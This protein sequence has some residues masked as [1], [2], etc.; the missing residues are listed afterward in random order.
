MNT[1]VNVMFGVVT[2]WIVGVFI[3]G[4]LICIPANKFWNQSLAGTCLN[5]YQFYY[6]SQIPNILTDVI[7][8]IMPM[9][10]VWS[11]HISKYQKMLLCGVFAV[12]GLYV[13]LITLFPLG[14]ILTGSQNLD[15]FN[16]PHAGHD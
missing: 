4:G 7:L 12:G 9:Q 10:V 14:S 15:L 16:C 2:L 8:L 3:A 11:L 6:G 13:S 5:P 1:A